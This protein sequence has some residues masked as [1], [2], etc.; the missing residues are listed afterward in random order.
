MTR[1]EP[2]SQPPEPRMC[3]VCKQEIQPGDVATRV[4]GAPMHWDCP[5]DVTGVPA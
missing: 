1:R 4:H 2:G 3:W 5:G